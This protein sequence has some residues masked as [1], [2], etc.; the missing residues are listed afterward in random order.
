MHGFSNFFFA[1][2]SFVN[3]TSDR[4]LGLRGVS[5]LIR[6]IA[7][8]KKKKTELS[9]ALRRIGV[10]FILCYQPLRGK[11]LDKIKRFK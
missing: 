6:K 11:A 10:E 3:N 4:V 9:E 5:R 2:N 1:F 8:H 7:P